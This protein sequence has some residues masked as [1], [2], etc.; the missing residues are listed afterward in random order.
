MN[1]VTEIGLGAYCFHLSELERPI[2]V[3]SIPTYP[4]K[5]FRIRFVCFPSMNMATGHKTVR[6]TDTISSTRRFPDVVNLNRDVTKPP[7]T[8]PSVLPNKDMAPVG[9]NKFFFKESFMTWPLKYNKFNDIYPYIRLNSYYGLGF[10]QKSGP[11]FTSPRIRQF[12]KSKT[13]ER[14]KWMTSI[15]R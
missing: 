1:Q 15:L 13:S 14:T 10:L 8:G 7:H 12:F 4:G 3:F 2:F 11:I 6:I 9:T 5:S